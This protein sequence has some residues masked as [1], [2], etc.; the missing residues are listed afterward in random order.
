MKQKT[1]I[2]NKKYLEILDDHR[3][4]KWRLFQETIKKTKLTLSIKR[5]ACLPE[6]MI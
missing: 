5:Q 3:M 2:K 6:P 1:T 4:P